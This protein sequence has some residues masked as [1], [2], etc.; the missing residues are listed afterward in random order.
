MDEGFGE[1]EG[2]FGSSNPLTTKPVLD[3]PW[4]TEKVSSVAVTP[5][6]EEILG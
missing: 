3:E 2:Q 6:P 4:G 5:S 1:S